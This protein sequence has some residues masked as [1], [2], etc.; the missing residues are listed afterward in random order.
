MKNVDVVKYSTS[1]KNFIKKA[2]PKLKKQIKDTIK[3]I[4]KIPSEGD[5]KPMS[6]F[7]DN[8]MRIRFGK[9]RIIYRYDEEGTLLILYIM[10]IGSRGDIYK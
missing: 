6:G 3:G 2:D 1:A 4:M 10:D 8:R 7:S 5:I 9:Y